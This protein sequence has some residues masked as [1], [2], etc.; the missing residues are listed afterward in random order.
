ME[1]K[2]KQKDEEKLTL[3][4][5]FIARLRCVFNYAVPRVITWTSPFTHSNDKPLF[6][7][8]IF[9]FVL[10]FQWAAKCFQTGFDGDA[11]TYICDVTK[12]ERKKKFKLKLFVSKSFFL[13]QIHLAL[14]LLHTGAIFFIYKFLLF[15]LDRIPDSTPVNQIKILI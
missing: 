3:A 2:K 4:L 15:F 12:K 6:F 9:R 5:T 14:V 11:Y 8:N 7:E 13:F 1:T 10:L